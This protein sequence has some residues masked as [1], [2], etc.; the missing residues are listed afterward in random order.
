MILLE[1]N[2]NLKE[3]MLNYFLFKKHLSYL[4]SDQKITIPK[5]AKK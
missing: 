4:K 5:Q 3:N 1:I 2:N